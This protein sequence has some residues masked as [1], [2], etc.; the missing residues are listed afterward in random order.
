[1]ASL[2]RLRSLGQC[3]VD[4]GSVRI[5]QDAKMRFALLLF[6][7]LERGKPIARS[8]IAEMLWPD[9]AISRARH[10]L[11]HLAYV[12]R[13]MGVPAGDSAHAIEL[14]AESVELDYELALAERVPDDGYPE[15]LPGYAPAFS[16]AFSE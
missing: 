14:P 13:A 6:L 15:F 3:A 12:L 4:V 8:T 9:V 2:V 5:G 10:S 7:A 1:M 16:N 11:R